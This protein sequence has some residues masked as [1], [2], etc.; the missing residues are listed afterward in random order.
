[1]FRTVVFLRFFPEWVRPFLCLL[2]PSYWHGQG[3]IRSAKRLLGPK[4]HELLRKNDEGSWS[5]RDNEDDSNVLSWLAETA[6][7]GDRDPDTL[8]HVEVMLTLASVHTS[9][10]R[11]V[12]VLYDLTASPRYFKQLQLEI[13]AQSK[14][15]QGWNEASYSQ[16]RKLDSVLRE[17]QRM[18][19]PSVLGM[20]RL[21]KQPHTF[22]DGLHVPRGTYT[23]LPTFA[24]ENDPANTPRPEV[25]DGLRNYRNRQQTRTV[26]SKRKSNS[27]EHEYAS[28]E[29]NA[30]NFGYGKSACPGRY[31]A[32]L[33]T[34]ILFVKLL[35]EYEFKFLPGYERPKNIMVH[36]FLFCWPWQKMLIRRKENGACPY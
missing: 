32:S 27:E 19:P 18:S 26:D 4:I 6:K 25:F 35:T 23:C 24:I 10:L 3:Y 15:E 29:H 13:E 5:P 31:F 30:L 7:G 14:S 1:M 36:E 28:A 21:F 8:A 33:A 22:A 16:L 20:R 17:S 2:I 9:T 34:K 11:M 12:N